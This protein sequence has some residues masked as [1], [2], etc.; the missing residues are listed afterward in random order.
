[1]EYP[2]PLPA[3]DDPELTWLLRRQ[4][5]LIHTFAAVGLV[6]PGE[7]RLEVRELF[8]M[9]ALP[10]A[11]AAGGDDPPPAWSTGVYRRRCHLGDP[12]T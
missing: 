8:R 9:W 7:A 4:H 6:G 10:G 11:V 2:I 3:S 12:S 1:M 5:R